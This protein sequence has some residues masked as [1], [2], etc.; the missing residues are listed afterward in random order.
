MKRVA[1]NIG[2]RKNLP[3]TLNN[4]LFVNIHLRKSSSDLDIVVVILILI[5]LSQHLISP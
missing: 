5:G 1:D 2:L 3:Q 4:F